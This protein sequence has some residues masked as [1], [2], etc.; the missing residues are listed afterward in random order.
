MWNCRFELIKN[1]SIN[2]FDEN[3]KLN[4]LLTVCSLIDLCFPKKLPLL[5]VYQQTIK[6]IDNLVSENWLKIYILWEL[7]ILSEVGY[8]LDLSKCCVS[9]VK[10]DLLYVSPN[11]GKAVCEK[12]GKKYKKKLLNLPDFLLN[13]TIQ[14]NNNSLM[15]GLDL[16]GFFLD[17][18]LKKN[19]NK[20]LPFYRRKI[21]Q[22]QI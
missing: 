18:Y 17:K 5:K 8:G 13:K 20:I 9:G 16:T 4:T 2:F 14:P 10:K 6:T 3:I 19:H 7:F 12:V 22:K 11:S 21:Y 15:F 1:Y